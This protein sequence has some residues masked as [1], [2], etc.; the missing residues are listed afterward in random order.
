MKQVRWLLAAGGAIALV[1]AGCGSS[2]DSGGDA[3]T[4]STSTAASTTASAPAKCDGTQVTYQLGYIPNPQYVGFLVAYDKG[5]FE[6]EGIEMEMKPGGPTV[7][8]ALQVAQGTVDMTDIPLSDALNA[9]SK[10]GEM[11]LVAQTAQQTPLRYISW[12]ETPL[13][14]PE[15][16]KGKSVGIQQAGNV[17]PE[18]AE[19]LS[20]V[21]LSQDDVTVKTIN[22]DV[23]DFMAKKVDVF[24]LRTYAHIAMLEGEGVT[25]PDDVNVLD[26][27]EYGA[28]LPD[29]G[30]YANSEF[31]EQNPDAVVCVLRAIAAGWEAT[32]ADPAEAKKIVAEYAPAAAFSPEAI[33][34]DV[35]EAI[36][37]ATT[38]SAGEK[39]EPLS[40]D[41][42]YI[43][44]GAEKLHSS[45]A[46]K[47]EV[48][49][50]SVIELGPLEEATG[51][52]GS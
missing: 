33:D 45:G 10:G 42:D 39:V 26:P 37:Y 19:M 29:E 14:T 17:T 22:F 36:K 40:V 21:G 6:D 23:S 16:L 43:T 24:P 28:G 30:I 48:D 4:G 20:S 3:A 38:N 13:A 2:D 41:V 11:K 15:D 32:E 7:N 51:S 44:D 12:K 1:A 35:D 34:V 46:V 47:G 8:P 25:Y 18:M 27:N 52:A 50:E 9:I 5:F 49:I 31:V